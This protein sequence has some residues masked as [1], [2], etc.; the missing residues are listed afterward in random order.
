MPVLFRA[1]DARDGT[2]VTCDKR[3]WERHIAFEH[4][5]MAGQMEAV[6]RTIEEPMSIYQIPAHLQRQAFFRPSD[7]PPHFNH[8]FIRVIVEYNI[9]RISRRKEGSVVTAFHTLS[10]P[11]RGE[12][13]IWPT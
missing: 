9:G 8:G 11:K 2:E 6:R 7:L 5:E 4:P 13:M 3:N 12:V 1:I 10:G